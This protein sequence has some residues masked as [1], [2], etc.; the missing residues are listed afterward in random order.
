MYG[1]IQR[2]SALV[3]SRKP[4]GERLIQFLKETDQVDWIFSCLRLGGSVLTKESVRKIL[5]GE[6][7]T[8]VALA[9][10][11]KLHRYVEAMKRLEGMKEMQYD[12]LSSSGMKKLYEALYDEEPHYRR[13]DPV[14]PQWD[15][16]PPHFTELE[17]QMSLLYSE[18]DEWKEGAELSDGSRSNPLLQACYLHMRLL[19]V[20]PFGEETED[21]ARFALLYEMNCAGYPVTVISMSEQEYNICVMNFLRTGDIRPFYRVMERAVYNKLEVILQI[22]AEDER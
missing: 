13:R 4:Y 17:E 10:H 8:D 12:L 14:L 9:D 1:E 2:K 19:E 21:L 7:V 11:L 3:E 18:V 15:H 22:T 6:L 5:Q 16:L 20:Y